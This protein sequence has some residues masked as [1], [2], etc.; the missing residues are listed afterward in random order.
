MKKS[1]LLLVVFLAFTINLFSQNGYKAEYKI[2][3]EKNG[4]SPMHYSLIGDE[5]QSEFKFIERVAPERVVAD[6]FSGQVFLNPETPDSIQPFIFT[7]RK[8]NK[9][10]ST[11]FITEDDGLSYTMY[12]IIEP[13][14]VKWEFE[15]EVKKIDGFLCKKATTTFRGRNYIA[16]YSDEIPVSL[17]PWKFHG[18]PGLVVN[19]TDSKNEVSFILEKIKM[20]YNHSIG[21]SMQIDTLN[22]IPVED[23]IELRKNAKLKS[24]EFFEKKLLSK[25]PRGANIELVE[26]GNNDIE[27]EM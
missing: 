23:F 9:I 1:N 18:L 15:S 17:G 3:L 4:F 20:P 16:W 25:L 24:R 8:L 26:E 6:E 5:S 22:N 14:T 19:I 13:I 12:N 10:Y 21:N 7:N 11:D 2:L 27:I